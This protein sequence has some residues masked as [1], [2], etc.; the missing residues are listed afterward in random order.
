MDGFQGHKWINLTNGELEKYEAV[1][2]S[3]HETMS[4]FVFIVNDTWDC[5]FRIYL[6]GHTIFSIVVHIIRDHTGFL[7]NARRV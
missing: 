3:I 4:F 5:K 2:D 6:G 7:I 1:R